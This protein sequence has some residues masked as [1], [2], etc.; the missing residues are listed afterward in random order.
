MLYSTKSPRLKMFDGDAGVLT[1]PKLNSKCEPKR[2]SKS[3]LRPSLGLLDATSEHYYSLAH[4][5]VLLWDHPIQHTT[6]RKSQSA[7]RSLLARV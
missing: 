1:S 5:T 6:P 2:F 4:D 3:I 7:E